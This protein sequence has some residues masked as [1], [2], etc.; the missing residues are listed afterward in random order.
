MPPPGQPMVIRD[1]NHGLQ[2]LNLGGLLGSNGSLRQMPITPITTDDFASIAHLCTENYDNLAADVNAPPLLSYFLQ[3][4]CQT[5]EPP[6][7]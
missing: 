2:P 7:F 6:K 3:K 5:P 4:E 1:T